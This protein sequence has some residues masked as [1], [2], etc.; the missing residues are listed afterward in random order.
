MFVK[1]ADDNSPGD[2]VVDYRKWPLYDDPAR[3]PESAPFFLSPSPDAPFVD[4]T[5]TAYFFEQSNGRMVLF[6]NV[7]PRTIVSSGPEADYHRPRGGYGALA[8]EVIH[9]LDDVGL[10]FSEYDFNKD[11]RVDHIFLIIRND[12][13]KMSGRITWTGA[14]CLDARCANGPPVG[15][16]I[17]PLR[18]DNVLV[19]WNLSG[20]ILFNRV[21][22]N[23]IPHY[24]LIRMMAHEIGH[25]FWARFFIHVPAITTNDVPAESNYR[26]PTNV[27]GYVL[28]AGAGG[29]RDARG[30]E[31][32]SA[33]ERS[34]LGWID[35][36]VLSSSESGVRLRDL[37]TSGDCR[38][39]QIGEPKRERTLFLSNRQRI[40]AF[41]RIRR[42]G[43]DG[44]FDMGLLRT[45]GLLVGLSDRNRYEV[46]PADNSLELALD[47]ASYAGDL[48]GPGSR[49]QLTPWT[50]PTSNGYSERRPA[51]GGSWAA[52]DNIRSDAD[53]PEVMLFDFVEDFRTRPIIREDSWMAAESANQEIDAPLV[54]TDGATLT[55]STE[56]TL[57]GR[58][59]VDPGAVLH[60]SR[61]A[62]LNLGPRST[63]SLD[64]GSELRIDGR[65]NVAGVVTP[66]AGSTVVRG[67]TGRVEARIT[68]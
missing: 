14:S 59:R 57:D 67:R 6:G 5:L 32:I 54:I 3:L 40:G 27:L 22:G 55:V 65:L 42:G 17:E 60:I 47:N 48:F 34:L 52:I 24:W 7:Y 66:R 28:M 51:S 9:R 63:L 50:R 46:L 20:S 8:T 39:I 30:D 15:K 49:S 26:P 23:I 62:T 16:Y 38:R 12:T 10:D 18:V 4:S 64:E 11:G 35:C 43:N 37:Y 1:F 31:T 25:D 61:N 13:E 41:D 56:L 36:P 68:R 19:D 53:D 44:R 58:V 21:P 33:W 45:T 29:G 2:P